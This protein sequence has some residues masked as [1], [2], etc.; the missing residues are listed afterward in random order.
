MLLPGLVVLVV[1][2]VGA[3]SHVSAGRVGCAQVVAEIDHIT[4]RRGSYRPDASRIARKLGVDRA[5]VYRC[6]E[7]YGR[8]MSRRPAMR[9][10]VQEEL[11]A[12]WEND[13]PEEKGPEEVGE[14][15]EALTRP[16]KPSPQR[17]HQAPPT[18]S[19]GDEFNKESF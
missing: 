4:G 6:A 7:L 15:G 9:D 3:S 8:R 17:K 5:W 16:A 18:P 10:G 1:L 13:E 19:F 2:A 11:E 14:D 12:G